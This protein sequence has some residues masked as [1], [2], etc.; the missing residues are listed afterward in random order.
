VDF[1][2]DCLADFL[3]LLVSAGFDLDGDLGKDLDA[4]L[5]VIFGMIRV[6]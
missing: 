5:R 3:P 4:G 1:P 6:Y 2:A